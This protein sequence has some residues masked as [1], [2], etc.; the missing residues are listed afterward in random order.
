VYEFLPSFSPF[1]EEFFLG[2]RLINSFSDHLSFHSQ[3]QDVKNHLYNLDNI[4]INMSSDP[5]SSIVISNASIRNVA[6]SI[7]HIHLYNKP[8]IKM[9]H[10]AV[11][12]TTTEAELLV[13]RYGINQ[14][15]C[16]PNIKHIV[17]IMDSLHAA[18]KIFE[19]SLHPYQIHSATIS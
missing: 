9:I 2:K 18:K 10:H 19:S 14:A 7:L 4:T 11:N 5:Y 3:T 17:V 13:I 15:V 1:D 12:I 6:T 8:I 16:I